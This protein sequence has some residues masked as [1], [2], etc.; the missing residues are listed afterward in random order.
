MFSKNKSGPVYNVSRN[1]ENRSSSL[2][3]PF[4]ITFLPVSH[5]SAQYQ[6]SP[7]ELPSKII[8]RVSKSRQAGLSSRSLANRFWTGMPTSES[9]RRQ[10]G[11]DDR[12]PSNIDSEGM[13][14][15]NS[16]SSHQR[17]CSEA[18]ALGLISMCFPKYPFTTF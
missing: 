1:A 11:D 4:S 5:R 13:K 12:R 10:L 7:S 18:I 8:S 15:G 9:N 2:S 17:P 14:A 16:K 6:E 3:N